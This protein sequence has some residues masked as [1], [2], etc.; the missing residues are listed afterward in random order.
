MAEAD[1][2]RDLAAENANPAPVDAVPQE[3]IAPVGRN[4]SANGRAR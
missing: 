3:A 4:R 1:P 2:Q